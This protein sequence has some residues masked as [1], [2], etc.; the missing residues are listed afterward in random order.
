M[1]DLVDFLV[2]EVRCG[3]HL[4]NDAH[5]TGISTVPL[6]RFV[7]ELDGLLDCVLG[8]EWH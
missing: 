6:G 2:V 7:P 3:H 1:D 4:V 5:L 8:E